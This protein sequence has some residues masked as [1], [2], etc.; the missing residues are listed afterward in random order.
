MDLEQ[1]RNNIIKPSLKPLGL[2]AQDIEALLCATAAQETQGG[3]HLTKIGIPSLGIYQMLEGTHNAIWKRN[4][5]QANNLRL[6]R[7]MMKQFGFGQI[8]IAFDMVWHNGYAT[9]MAWYFYSNVGAKIPPADD[10]KAQWEFYNK[11]WKLPANQSTEQDF[12][13]NVNEYF[14]LRKKRK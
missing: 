14:G 9:F 7:D 10:L 13:R 6:A 4:F 3:R 12:Y 1:L 8:P 11:Y 5:Q 2:W